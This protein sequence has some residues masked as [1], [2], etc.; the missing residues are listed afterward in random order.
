MP[1]ARSKYLVTLLGEPTRILKNTPHV[2]KTATNT[3]RDDPRYDE[4]ARRFEE[5][6]FDECEMD[7]VKEGQVVRFTWGEEDSSVHAEPVVTMDRVFVS[8]IFGT[9]AEMKGL[10]EW[11][12][13]VYHDGLNDDSKKN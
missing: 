10:A 6:G 5:A 7:H 1:F 2:I 12:E 9:E 8:V 3:Y 13:E 11:R 4:V